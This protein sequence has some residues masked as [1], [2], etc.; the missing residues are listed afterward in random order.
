MF[1]KCIELHILEEQCPARFMDADKSTMSQ[2]GDSLFP[3]RFA[4]PKVSQVLA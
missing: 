1:P 3:A 2:G 4:K